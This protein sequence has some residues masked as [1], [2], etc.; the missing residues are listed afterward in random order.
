[1]AFTLSATGPAGVA[2]G[3]RPAV[4]LSTTRGLG[5][6]TTVESFACSTVTTTLQTTCSGTTVGDAVQGSTVTVRF[7]LTTGGTADVT[8]I[9]TGVS[10]PPL[11]PPPPPILL[12]PPSPLLPVPPIAAGPASFAEVP[13]IPES[14]SVLLLVGGLAGLALLAALRRRRR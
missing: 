10:P 5:A 12:P 14:D 7:A 8:G 1:M 9:I 3:G 2:V 4:F 11:L 6:P 13:V